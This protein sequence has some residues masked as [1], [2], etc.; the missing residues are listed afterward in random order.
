MHGIILT[1]FKD[2]VVDTYDRKMWTT[3]QREADLP[4]RL[5]VP[6]EEYP[7]EDV[8]ALLDAAS[9]LTDTSVPDLLEAF[10]EYLVPPLLE[11]YG[12][13]VERD[14]T[15]LELIANIKA[16]H[17]ALREKNISTYTT[18]KVETGWRD[19][20]TVSVIYRSER[21]FCHLARG[22]ILGVSDHFDEPYEISEPTCMHEGDGECEFLVRQVAN[23]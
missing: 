23:V 10:G 18:P 5:Y 20:E 15:G 3:L 4:S 21:Q 6:V 8:F 16:F 13:H 17:R 2:F 7:D 1:K 11:T 9:E 19:S 22:L 12:V 14:W